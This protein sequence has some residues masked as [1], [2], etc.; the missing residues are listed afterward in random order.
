MFPPALFFWDFDFSS[1]LT[2]SFFQVNV[3]QQK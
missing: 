3:I 1:Y 2:D